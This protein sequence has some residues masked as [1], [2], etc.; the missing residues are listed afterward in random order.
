MTSLE[1]AGDLP[2]RQADVSIDGASI[3]VV[4]DE[5]SSARVA[6]EAVKEF[7][8]CLVATSGEVALEM[9]VEDKP[10]LILLDIS[11]PGMDGYEVLSHL[12]ADDRT[13]DIPVIFVTANDGLQSEE[14]GLK[15]GAVDYITKPFWPP[16]VQ[17]RVRHH[18]KLVFALRRLTSLA[19]TD[20]LTGAFNRRRFMERAEEMLAWRQ[21]KGL[22][23]SVVMVDVDRF[24]SINDTFG[25]AVGD[26]ALKALVETLLR[27]LRELDALGRL[28]GEEFAALL[29]ETDGEAAADV[30]ER[31]RRAVSTIEVPTDAE[32]LRFTASFGVAE[33]TGEEIID[34]TLARA[35]AALYRSK[36]EGRDRVTVASP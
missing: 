21:Q 28:G 11:M 4:D 6:V 8:D 25:H 12:M 2:M 9:A 24:K 23:V 19:T 13:K 5:P 18:L 27:E 15:Q 33:V 16:I 36:Q 31:L 10:D 3:L 1:T 17:A 30:A 14:Q 7:G 35:D 29:P 34:H 32:T 20:P 26:L 22:A